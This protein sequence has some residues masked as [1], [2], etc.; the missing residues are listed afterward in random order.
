M[1]IT[2]QYASIDD[3]TIEQ[4]NQLGSLGWRVHSTSRWLEQK[5][6]FPWTNIWHTRYMFEK[7]VIE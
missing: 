6:E 5:M 3:P 7:Q 1:A 2:F 4:I